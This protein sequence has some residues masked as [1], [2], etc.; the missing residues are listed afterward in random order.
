MAVSQPAMHI[1]AFATDVITIP[2]NEV[3]NLRYQLTL[4]KGGWHI[5]LNY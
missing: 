3:L 4:R 5:W 1:G 2:F